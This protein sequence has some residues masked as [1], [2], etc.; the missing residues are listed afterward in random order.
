MLRLITLGRLLLLRDGPPSEPIHLQ[1]KRLALLAYLALS[2]RDGYLQRDTLLALF[3]PRADREHARRC[4][5]QALFHLR[6]ELGDGVLVNRGREGLALAP[7][8]LWCDAAEVDN[9][10]RSH[11]REEALELY[12]GDF[13]PGLFVERGGVELEEWV[14]Q[15]R[16]RLRTAAAACA[17]ELADDAE[18]D[19]RVARMLELAHRA[20]ALSPEDEQGLR[21]HMALLARA[22]DSAAAL[23]AYADFT[24]RLRR[25]YD[26]EPSAASLALASDLRRG[27]TPPLPVVGTERPNRITSGLAEARPSPRDRS[28]RRQHSRLPRIVG[29]RH[30]LGRVTAAGLALTAGLVLT[31]PATRDTMS[32]AADH[33]VLADFANHTRD[34][35]LGVAVNEAVRSELSKVARVDLAGARAVPPAPRSGPL[36]PGQMLILVTG[37]VTPFGSGF[38]VS[39]RLVAA[40][41]GQLL[42][43]VREESTDTGAL[44]PAVRRLSQRLKGDLLQTLGTRVETGVVGGHR[45]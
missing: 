2:A 9:A 36:A 16:R 41:S 4:L 15:T 32:R 39:A 29:V 26:A 1:P 13:L 24:R 7:D 34:S 27:R 8:R 37:D 40:A 35:L 38:A 43:V 14:D 22:G 31:E 28:V 17:W 3:W 44:Q 11:R 25:D 23:G 33:L 12:T 10:L 18:R 42:G 21:R 5:R 20:R 30:R 6:N 45:Y 19:G